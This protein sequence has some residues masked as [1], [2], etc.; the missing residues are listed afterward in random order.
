MRWEELNGAGGGRGVRQ[1]GG[2]GGMWECA[3][4]GRWTSRWGRG[5]RGVVV[6]LWVVKGDRR[7]NKRGGGL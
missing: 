5:R 1:R 3:G 2:E 6:C 4:K 7:K